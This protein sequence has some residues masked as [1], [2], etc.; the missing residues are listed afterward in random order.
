MT[1]EF[2]KISG[3]SGQFAEYDSIHNRYRMDPY[4][5]WCAYGAFAPTLQKVAFRVL[6]QPASSCS[7][8]RNWITCSFVH[9]VKR[10]KMTSQRAEDLVFVHSN[11]RLLSRK[12]P[13]YSQGQ[14]KMWDIAADA[15]DS[16]DDVGILGVAELS[17]L[18][19]SW[20]LLCLPMMEMMPMG[21][22]T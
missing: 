18:N 8:E 2:G 20:R 21:M 9:T 10:N 11:P 12:S 22:K 14:N 7:C 17:L 16:I 19:L 4:S 6:G 1:I 5:W 3:C 13:Q 15:F